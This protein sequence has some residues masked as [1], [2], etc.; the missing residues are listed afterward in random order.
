[1]K[2]KFFAI[3]VLAS[4][5]MLGLVAAAITLSPS[6]LTFDKNDTSKNFTITNSAGSNTTNITLTS[7]TISDANGK[8]I[9]IGFNVSTPNITAGNTSTVQA[10]VTSQETGFLLGEHSKTYTITDTNNSNTTASLTL[11]FINSFCSAG[12]VNESD[13]KLKVDINNDGQGDDNEWIPLD[14]IK[15]DVELENNGDVDL[16]N[17]IFELGMYK[18]NSNSDVAGDMIWISKDDEQFE[19]GD[20]NEDKKKSHTFEFRV[21]PAEVDDSDYNIVVK[22]Y[23]KGDQSTTCIDHSSDF[24]ESTFGSSTESIA[25]ISVVKETDISKMVV[26]DEDVNPITAFCGETVSMTRSVYNVGDEDFRDQIKVTLN[27]NELGINLEDV[28]LGDFDQGDKAET[29]FSFVV[30]QNAVEKQ[31]TLNMDTFYDYDEDDKTYDESSDETFVAYLKVQGNCGAA[32]SGKVA[33]SPQLQ[34]GGEAGEEMVIKTT[35]RNTGNQTATYM[36]NAAGYSTWASSASV[37]P[38]TVTVPAGGFTDVLIT[39][40]VK[41]DASG[42]QTFNIELVSNGALVLTQ[43]VSASIEKGGFSFGKISLEGNWYLWALGALNVILV[44]IIIIVAIRLMRR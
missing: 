23:P 7:Q 2:T 35:I 28:I 32:S 11:K 12:S 41:D 18:K 24:A 31:Y 37:N 13:L 39:L 19:V 20:I 43:P 38:T 25:E 34:S 8:T 21:D 5:L 16:D 14:T 4:I 42:N 40:D 30:P 9:T 15:I 29:S 27:N 33:V 26:I 3:F 17:V 36:V 1:M 22:A 10:N 6:T 44:I